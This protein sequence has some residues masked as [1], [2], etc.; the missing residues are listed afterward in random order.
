MLTINQSSIE[1]SKW[2]TQIARQRIK[3][4][5]AYG[6][7][8]GLQAHLSLPA[9][10][11]AEVTG[12]HPRTL[13]RRRREGVFTALESD[14]LYRFL[15]LFRRASDALESEEA[16][17]SWLARPN[18]YFEGLTPLDYASTE[19]GYQELLLDIES[20]ADDSFG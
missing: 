20:I 12:I 18:P 19:P 3:D 2:T 6:E 13:Q 1:K 8:E 9:E 17:A 7:F 5:L 15:D 4:G 14:R 16:A 11:L 10:R